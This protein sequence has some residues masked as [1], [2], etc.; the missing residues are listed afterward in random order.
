MVEFKSSE[1]DATISFSVIRSSNDGTDFYV[2]VKS[3]FGSAKV[4]S[5]TFFNGSPAVLFESMAANWK[6]WK[7]EKVW[8]DLENAVVLT[9]R[10]D[11]TGHTKL[12]VKL[13]DYESSF[14]TAL[15]FEA[16]KLESMAYEITRLLP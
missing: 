16:G 2:E 4:Q 10:S 5:S 14:E 8:N 6:G 3:P 9:A 15:V 13:T 12:T 11:S 1:N 7:K